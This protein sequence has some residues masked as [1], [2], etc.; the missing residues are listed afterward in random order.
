MP[1]VSVVVPVHD[2]EDFLPECLASLAAQTLDD[3]EVVLVDDD[4]SDRSGEIAREFAAGRGAWQVLSVDG[5][6]PGAAR[7]AGISVAT[8]TYLSFVDADDVVPADGIERLTAVLEQTGSDIACGMAMR[9]DGLKTWPS[10]LQAAAIRET[11]LRTHISR[12]P[13]LL[14]D[15]TVWAKLYRRSFWDGAGLSFP[16]GVHFED[17]SVATIAQLE[18][19]SVDL[20]EQPVYWWRIRQ[21][22]DQSITQRRTEVGNLED[23]M[24]ALRLIDRYLAER[25][26]TVLKRAHDEKVLRHDLPVHM[27]ALPDADREF[28]ERFVELA[29]EFV[30]SVEPRTL[31]KLKAA[32]RLPYY[33]AS[34]GKVDEVV[35]VMDVARDPRRNQRFR[36]RG[37]RMYA[38][39]PFLFDK[40]VGVPPA[41]YDV[42]RSQPMSTGIRD[43]T[44][45]GTELSIDGHAYIDRSSMRWPWSSGIRVSARNVDDHSVRTGLRSRRRRRV[46]VSAAMTSEAI[47][48]DWSGFLARLD[49]RSLV[50]ASSAPARWELVVQVATAGARRGGRLG[51][52]QRQRARHP[53]HVIVDGH[54]VA[55]YYSEDRWLTVEVWQPSLVVDEAV[56]RDGRLELA[57]RRLDGAGPEPRIGLFRRDSLAGAPLQLTAG[58]G[59]RFSASV[60]LD[61]FAARDD[62]VTETDWDLRLMADDGEPG[63]RV[64]AAEQVRFSSLQHGDRVLEPDVSDRGAVYLR[65]R[66]ATPLVTQLRLSSEGLAF[67]GTLPA[68]SALER[69][70]LEHPDG[71]SAVLT[72]RADPHEDAGEPTSWHASF[73]ADGPADGPTALR[74]LQ[75]G[76]WTAVAELTRGGRTS[77]RPVLVA[78][79][80]LGSVHGEARASGTIIR[81]DVD[82]S[83]RLGLTV[84]A[85]GPYTDRGAWRERRF[86]RVVYRTARRRPVRDVVLFEA[87]RGKSFSDSPQAVYD[88]LRRS[89]PTI[90][91]VWAVTSLATERPRD[92]DV[93][94]KGSRR[95]WELL[96]RARWVVANDSLPTSYRRR[97]GQSYLQTWHG[98]PLKRLAFDVPELKI[99]NRNYLKEFAVEVA[100]W[101]WLVSPNP[102]STEVMRRAFRYD[103]P[104]LETGYPRNDVFYHPD[105][106][107]E[108]VAATRARLD[109]PEGRKVVLYAP[110]WRD[111]RFTPTGQYQFDMRLNLDKLRHTIGDDWVVL[112]RGHHILARGVRIS[113]DVSSFVRNVTSYP[114]IQDLY[115]VADAVVTD[116][117]SVMFDYANTGRPMVF[118]TWDLES[119]RDELRGFYFDLEAQAPGPLVRTTEEVAEMLQTLPA[120][121]AQYAER[122]AA[123]RER[124]CSLEDGEASR[125]VVKAVWG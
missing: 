48:Y 17:M 31:A 83:R 26:D 47:S 78:R 65:D 27:N 10:P 102:F 23:R 39:L 100:Q 3:L 2:V 25:S 30:R 18:A 1:L 80:A 101:S 38:E 9:Y 14:R 81:L 35:E 33:L 46:D 107:A 60:S 53:R 92:V 124:F 62:M 97:D 73:A 119:Y 104:V 84:D 79:D 96:A 7:N 32:L 118:F 40:A 24:T 70:V 55:P 76:T 123:F 69:L 82:A 95:Y 42:T 8:G 75:S 93:V 109:L 125:R 87:W 45:S 115:L 56:L 112:I 64:A 20:I 86:R 103:G 77:R 50:R 72:S 12:T 90:R 34:R 59:D 11:R 13:A 110:T 91:C 6:S 94:V 49:V 89:H 67:G 113:G 116:Y 15:T 58:P 43:V 105:V 114:D 98:T 88:E 74:W 68:G 120:V 51:R 52:P 54:V 21:S 28:Q 5:H 37:L 106:V 36:R 61:A 22:D 57:G 117:S 29:G 44:W 66:E 99:A 121:Q 122:Y 19:C 71:S 41:V 108:R 4:S 111:N 63:E 85:K 16:E